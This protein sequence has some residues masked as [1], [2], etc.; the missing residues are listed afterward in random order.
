MESIL[1]VFQFM[2]YIFCLGSLISCVEIEEKKKEE[3]AL[4]KQEQTIVEEPEIIAI[5]DSFNYLNPDTTKILSEQRNNYMSSVSLIYLDYY[6]ERIGL[7]D[8]VVVSEWD[9]TETC[10]FNQEFYNDVLFR[11]N[12]CEEGGGFTEIYLPRTSIDSIHNLVEML[13][14][15]K[16]YVWHSETQYQP[17]QIESGCY[18]LIT[19]TE[20]NSIIKHS[21]GC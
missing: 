5:E 2:A 19:Q 20:K 3:K 15:E 17:A 21:C 13:Y 11:Q 8:S 14:F 6:F 16:E 7:K 18:T 1:R 9:S 10:A 4:T 12:Y